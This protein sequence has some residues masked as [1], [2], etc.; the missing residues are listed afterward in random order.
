[1][2]AAVSAWVAAA[3]HALRSPRLHEA[4]TCHGYRAGHVLVCR[5]W[6]GSSVSALVVCTPLDSR[7]RPSDPGPHTLNPEPCHMRAAPATA[8]E[9][10]V[11]WWAGHADPGLLPGAGPAGRGGVPAQAAVLRGA[12]APPHAPVCGQRARRRQDRQPARRCGL[13]HA[14]PVAC[15][16]QRQRCVAAAGVSRADRQR[17]AQSRCVVL[18]V[19][20]IMSARFHLLHGHRW[21]R[22]DRTAVHLAHTNH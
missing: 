6:T 11:C 15:C 3:E 20:F 22:S 16:A 21:A 19:L 7:P 14:W 17:E 10:A 9:L 2:L 13:A 12:E 1:M 4:S 18:C 8:A 5:S